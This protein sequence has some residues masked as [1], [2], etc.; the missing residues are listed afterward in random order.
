M[1]VGKV[2]V[3]YAYMGAFIFVLNTFC[4]AKLHKKFDMSKEKKKKM[5]KIFIF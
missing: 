4:G 3:F 2:C 1:V 5:Q